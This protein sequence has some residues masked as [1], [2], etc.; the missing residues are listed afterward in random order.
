MVSKAPLSQQ[1]GQLDEDLSSVSDRVA[2]DA[3]VT[4]VDAS[5]VLRETGSGED[6]VHRG[7]AEDETDR[8]SVAQ[9]MAEPIE[10]ATIIVVNKVDLVDK[11]SLA[12]MEALIAD[13]NPSARVL[14]S[15]YGRLPLGELLFTRSFDLALVQ[16]GPGWI[17]A[18]TEEHTP[19][20][21]AF[22]S[23][24]EQAHAH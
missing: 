8:R 16:S 19:E 1:P 13:L 4:A 5:M 11:A 21:E 10:F 9:L 6:I 14:R 17:Q 15:E 24:H 23:S 18:L 12:R 7:W 22:G 2:V 20:S 3:I